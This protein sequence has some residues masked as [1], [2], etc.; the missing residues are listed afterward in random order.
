MNKKNKISITKASGEIV[1][2]SVDRLKHSLEKSGASE[3]EIERIIKEI[4]SKLYDGIATKKIYR[5][6][7]DL[8]KESSN[9]L[10]A[11]YHVMYQRIV[12]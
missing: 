3:I 2:F 5:I 10:A 11:K 12:M 8:L 7:F 6:A 9:H 4:S 1:A